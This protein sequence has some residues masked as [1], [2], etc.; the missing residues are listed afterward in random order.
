MDI[1]KICFYLSRISSHNKRRLLVITKE[2]LDGEPAVRADLEAVLEAVQLADFFVTQVPA[3]QLKVAINASLV[4]RLGDD[5]PA[6]L[7]T[8]HEHDL[9]G[10]LA[11][12][13]RQLQQGWVLVERRVGGSQAG[14]TGAMDTLGVAVCNQ[15]GRGIVRVQFDLVDSGD[16][17]AAWVAQEDIEVLNTEVGD[18]NV[19]DFAGFRELLH[20]LPV[21]VV[22][23]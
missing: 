1:Y 18:T 20:F 23:T 13:L 22:N 19:L 10:S 4:H 5:T 17:L 21:L 3:V 12:L 2:D 15:L 16:D 7:H 9:L 8:P 6:L 11:L 14:I